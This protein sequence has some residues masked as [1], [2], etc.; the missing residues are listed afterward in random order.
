MELNDEEENFVK[1]AKIILDVLPK[2]LRVFFVDK[3]NSKYPTNQWTNDAASGQLLHNEIPQG[4]K[5]NKRSFHKTL[6]QMIL[7]GDIERWDPTSLFFVLLSAGL[8]LID[9]P[10]PMNHRNPPF[11]ESENIDRLRYIRST[12]FGHVAN[13]SIS[14]VEF[15]IISAE[16]EA[17]AKD[18][19]GNA[20]EIEIHQIVNSQ[21][22]TTL[23]EPLESQL[24]REYELFL[25]ILQGIQ[26]LLISF[27]W[28]CFLALSTLFIFSYVFFQFHI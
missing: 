9:A 2:H 20:A 11:N 14:A 27:Q 8:N 23:T 26:F 21:A 4:V 28:T 24:E 1:L 16:L 13:M 15:R 25:N 10:R 12:V 18:V 3:W 7:T 19:F 5:K 22:E 6:E 17:I